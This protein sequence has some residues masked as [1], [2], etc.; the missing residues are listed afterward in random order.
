MPELGDI[1]V[2]QKDAV[3]EQKLLFAFWVKWKISVAIKKLFGDVVVNPRPDV[4]IVVF[5]LSR[6]IVLV[7][8]IVVAF[9]LHW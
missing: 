1:F 7:L 9:I 8:L 6:I 2:E 4:W 3:I 5:Q